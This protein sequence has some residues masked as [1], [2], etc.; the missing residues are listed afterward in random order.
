MPVYENIGSIRNVD[1][2]LDIIYNHTKKNYASFQFEKI[3]QETEIIKFYNEQGAEVS[4][5]PQSVFKIVHLRDLLHRDGTPMCLSF[6]KGDNQTKKYGHVS[7]DI[8]LGAFIDSED[9]LYQKWLLHQSDGKPGASQKPKTAKSQ[10]PQNAIEQA[11]SRSNISIADFEVSTPSVT[12]PPPED[13]AW[14]LYNLLYMKES[15]LNKDNKLS[16]LFNYI[17]HLT[18]KVLL[19]TNTTYIQFN[20][21]KD[22]IMF[23]SRLLNK[24][25]NYIII[26]CKRRGQEYFSYKVI[27]SADDAVKL[28][29]NA[30]FNI[31]PI[32]FFS[33]LSQVVFSGTIDD[34][35]ANNVYKLNHIIEER[36]DRLPESMREMSS[37]D[38]SMRLTASIN[39]ALK[40]AMTDYKF[41][42]PIYGVSAR[43]IQFLIPVYSSFD[44]EGPPECAIIIDKNAHGQWETKTVLDLEMAYSHARLI[45]RPDQN[46]LCIS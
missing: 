40:I 39:M 23:N 34:F 5:G 38:I 27:K 7:D 9:K 30:E 1:H 3:L 14:E 12:A 36:R 2:I 42:V 28:G 25:G 16:R 17:I 15:W 18:T 10:V 4:D 32:S 21:K 46:W 6:I 11:M 43:R 19:E 41:I 31:A 24:Y 44:G 13:F 20:Q 29:F 37:I 35:D 8:W 45:T 22:R 26:S 33:S